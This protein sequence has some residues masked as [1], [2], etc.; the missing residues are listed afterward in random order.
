MKFVARLSDGQLL[1]IGVREIDEAEATEADEVVSLAGEEERRGG[2]L[3]RL[4]AIGLVAVGAVAV[5]RRLRG[6]RAEEA[7]EV[8]EEEP[9]E[10]ET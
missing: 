3:R 10:I 7:V 2:G 8:E 5:S 4:A 1:E 9:I 6:G